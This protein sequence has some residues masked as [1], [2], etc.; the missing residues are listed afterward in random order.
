MHRISLRPSPALVV[1][2]LALVLA[3]GGAAWARSSSGGGSRPTA[4]VIHACIHPDLG[5][6]EGQE[7]S[8]ADETGDCPEG[9][10][11]IAWNLEGKRGPKG[12]RGAKG[13]RGTRG[14]RGPKGVKGPIGATG[15]QGPVG[16][17]GAKGETGAPGETGAQGRV[18]PRGEAGPQGAPGARGPEGERG[19]EGA[20]GPQGPP[21]VPGVSGYEVVTDSSQQTVAA[22]G[23][24]TLFA[25]AICPTGK[26]LL[27][28]GLSMG[29]GTG[30]IEADGPI[31]EF[32]GTPQDKWEAGAFF[33]NPTG[34]DIDY[35]ITAIAYCGKVMS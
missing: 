18:G 16:P 5:G 8:L 34:G 20:P 25:D 23:N 32:D 14:V 31:L 28:G 13:H 27:G 3:L 2:C 19:L 12:Q 11:P 9:T 22:G 10:E 35:K 33:Q 29:G 7:L 26:K 30:Q 15:P 1:A 4:K 24:T 17:A 6:G 21:G